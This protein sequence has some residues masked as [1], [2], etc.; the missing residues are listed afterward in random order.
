MPAIKKSTSKTAKS[1]AP[2]TKSTRA[3]A[4]KAA[5]ARTAPAAQTAPVA[6]AVAALSVAAPKSVKAVPTKPVTTT[7][8]ACIDVGFGNSVYVRGEGPGLSWD[9]GVLMECLG[10]DQWQVALGES[11][12]PFLVKFLVNDQTWST[13]PDYTVP[14]GV[15]LTLAPQF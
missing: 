14:S 11:S 5:A 15:S 13:G 6:L 2:A 1:P 4:K 3:P 7:I 12:R 9:K 8:R 10:Q